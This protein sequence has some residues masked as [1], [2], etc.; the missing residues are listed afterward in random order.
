MS[1]KHT[2]IIAVTLQVEFEDD[3][4]MSLDDQ[5]HDAVFHRFDWKELLDF[6]VCE[7]RATDAQSQTEAGKP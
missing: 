1:A 3:G 7:I 4:E 5:A 2:A 6:E